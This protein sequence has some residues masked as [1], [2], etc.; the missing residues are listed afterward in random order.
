[1]SYD[2]QTAGGTPI[3][4]ALRALV[5]TAAVAGLLA[6]ASPALATIAQRPEKTIKKIKCGDGPSGQRCKIV[7]KAP[8]QTPPTP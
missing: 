4:T 1:L 8:D 5:C 7:V 6:A 3:L 2:A